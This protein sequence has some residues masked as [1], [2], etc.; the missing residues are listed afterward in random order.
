MRRD[1][2][3][4]LD[5]AEPLSG[6]ANQILSA[7]GAINKSARSILGTAGSINSTANSINGTVGSI[8]QS[9]GSIGSSVVQ[10]NQRVSSIGGNVS[11]INR[12]ARSIFAS[13]G[14]RGASDPTSIKASVNRILG[15]LR[16]LDPVTRSIDNG[17]GAPPLTVSGVSMINRRGDLAIGQARLIKGDF[18]NVL[19]NVTEIDKHAN[20]IDCARLLNIIGRTQSCNQ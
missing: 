18:G 9:V 2:A 8:N 15:E 11:S 3:D 13:V 10:I 16:A 20:S 14:P 17:K 4:I 12:L 6:Q 19:N 1:V 5:A 7:A